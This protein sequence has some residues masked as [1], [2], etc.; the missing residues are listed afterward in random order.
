[1]NISAKTR[2]CLIIGD[3]VGHSLSPAMHNAAYEA[4][5]IDDRFVFVA[6]QVP[7]DEVKQVVKTVRTLNIRGLTCTMPHKIEVMKHLD[8]IDSAANKI[9]AV[10]S[11]VNEDGILKGYNT[12]W[13]GAVTPLEKI[14]SLKNMPVAVIGAGG[15]ARAIIYGLTHRQACVTIFNRNLQKAQSLASEFNCKAKSLDNLSILPNFKI[16]INAT[17]L[18]MGE[19]HKLTPIPQQYLSKIHIVF[20]IVYDPPHTRLLTEAKTKGATVIAGWEMLLYQGTPQFELYTNRKAP[21]SVMRSVLLKH[22]K[23]YE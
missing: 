18:G 17:S 14:A 13:L 11:V 22:L 23:P 12:D 10:N 16:I 7:V 5:K 1:M 8:W 3:P 19:Q 15:A 20:D 6:A 4:L 21:E 9:G 2:L